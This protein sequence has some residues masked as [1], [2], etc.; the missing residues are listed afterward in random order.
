MLL[1]ELK[2][3]LALVG[4]EPELVCTV[5]AVKVIADGAVQVVYQLPDGTF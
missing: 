4:L 3:G 1:A 2:A 5:I